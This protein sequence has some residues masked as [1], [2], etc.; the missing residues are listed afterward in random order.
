MPRNITNGEFE[1]PYNEEDRVEPNAKF[2]RAPGYDSLDYLRHDNKKIRTNYFIESTLATTRH[3]YR[4]VQRDLRKL[5]VGV[6][7]VEGGGAVLRDQQL[8]R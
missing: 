6:E 5:H 8:R 4:G 3:P 2:Q 1:L 7:E